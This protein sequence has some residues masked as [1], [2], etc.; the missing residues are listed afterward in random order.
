MKNYWKIMIIKKLLKKNSNRYKIIYN[1]Y[2]IY[3]IIILIHLIAFNY[4]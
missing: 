1:L 4:N 2:F 3:N